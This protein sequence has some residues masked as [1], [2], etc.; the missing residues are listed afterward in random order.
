VLRRKTARLLGDHDAA[1]VEQNKPGPTMP[2]FVNLSP[3][4][5]GNERP[6]DDQ[7]K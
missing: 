1:S 7:M 6:V 4:A 2:R 3:A 5:L